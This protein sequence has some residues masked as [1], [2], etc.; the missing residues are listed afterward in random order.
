VLADKS[1][2]RLVE[3]V[4]RDARTQKTSHVRDRLCDERAGSRDLLDLA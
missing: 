1:P 3:L 2:G 4:G